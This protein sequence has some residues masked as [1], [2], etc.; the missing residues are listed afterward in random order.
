MLKLT[1]NE[2]LNTI[3]HFVLPEPILHRR[4]LEY[5]CLVQFAPFPNCVANA[6]RAFAVVMMP[7]ILCT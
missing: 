7:R 2:G 1:T 5:T 6:P 3:I 4:S